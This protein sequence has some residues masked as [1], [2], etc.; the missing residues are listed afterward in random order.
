[1][2]GNSTWKENSIAVEHFLAFEQ[3]RVSV[4]DWVVSLKVL[5]LKNL[6]VF[7][8]TFEWKSPKKI[9]AMEK[10]GLDYFLKWIL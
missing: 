10:M 8:I 6:T 7:L 4:S 9:N 5:N 3:K 2:C 1:M